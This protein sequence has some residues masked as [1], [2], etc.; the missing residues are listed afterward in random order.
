M[1]LQDDGT[2]PAPSAIPTTPS[3]PAPVVATTKVCGK[4]LRI[5]RYRPLSLRQGSTRI[6]PIK[7]G[8]Y[9]WLEHTDASSR[10]QVVSVAVAVARAVAGLAETKAPNARRDVTDRNGLVGFYLFA[11]IAV[12][13]HHE[14]H[15]RSFECSPRASRNATWCQRRLAK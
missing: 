14:T 9:A 10:P 6:P 15:I 5:V 1:V 2:T 12:F 13:S 11:G 4:H 3:S 7:L 8:T